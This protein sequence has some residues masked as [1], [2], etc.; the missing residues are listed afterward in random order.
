MKIGILTQPLLNNY[1]GLLQAHA[2]QQVLK[3][4]GH[5][6]W[7]INR[8]HGKEKPIRRIARVAKFFIY[9]F[10]LMKKGFP[11]P[12]KKTIK[13][14]EEEKNIISKNTS[15]FLKSY[16]QP[17]TPP[18]STDKKLKRISKQGYNAF[19]VGSDQVWRLDYSP[20]ITSYFLDFVQKR[21]NIKRVSYAASFGLSD[22]HYSKKLTK[23]CRKLAQKFDAISVREKSAVALCRDYLNVSALHLVDPTMLLSSNHYRDLT[24]KEQESESA[25]ELMVYIL[26]SSSFKEEL[27][28]ACSKKLNMKP[29]SVNAEKKPTPENRKNI[30]DCIYPPVTSWLKGFVDAKFVIT[31]SFHGCVFSILFNIPFIAI[32]NSKRGLARFESLLNMFNLENRLM[33]TEEHVD[34]GILNERIDWEG[35]NEKLNLE[36]KKSTDFLNANLTIH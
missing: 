1:G 11:S 12:L 3:S 14:T 27:I 29:F 18:I 20:K 33:Q 25:G 4:M 17:I 22:W 30:E 34:Y 2:M 28:D 21:H 23:E 5:E 19:V 7:I 32:G 10:L 35:V 13:I 24:V 6:V 16:I 9:R 36:R 15:K 8:I 31:D 26:D